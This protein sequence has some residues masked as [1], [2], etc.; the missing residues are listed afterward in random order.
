[1]RWIFL[2]PVLGLLLMACSEKPTEPEVVDQPLYVLTIEGVFDNTSSAFIPLP[3]DL[4]PS[5]IKGIKLEVWCD[6][7]G[8]NGSWVEVTTGT[9]IHF[10]GWSPNGGDGIVLV[11]T[12]YEG[13]EFRLHVY[14]T[15]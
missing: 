1:M 13:Q 10:V 4:S 9:A 12:G 7:C 3:A 15:R 14:Y 6:G 11:V 8:E 5:N 2:L